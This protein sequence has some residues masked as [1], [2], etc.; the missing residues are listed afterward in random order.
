MQVTQL[1]IHQYNHWSFTLLL[2]NC[3]ITLF[4][5]SMWKILSPKNLLHN[6]CELLFHLFSSRYNFNKA[7]NVPICHLKLIFLL[8]DTYPLWIFRMGS[9]F[10]DI[11]T[12]SFPRAL[13]C[14]VSV[15]HWGQFDFSTLAALYF[16][17]TIFFMS[18]NYSCGYVSLVTIFKHF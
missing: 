9:L 7:N 16:F 18:D 11:L 6:K 8:P 2:W 15:A 12:F 17:I 1:K 3:L 5:F 4:S 10:L 14:M 13:F